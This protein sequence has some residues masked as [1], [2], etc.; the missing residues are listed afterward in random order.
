[1]TM[2]EF[3]DGGMFAMLDQ[4]PGAIQEKAIRPAAQAGA[5]VLYDEVVARVPVSRNGHWF[6]GTTARDAP[7]GQKKQH[8]YWFDAGS[9]RKAIYQKHVPEKSA[10]GIHV[11]HIS[12][13]KT[14]PDAVPYGYMVE[15]GILG[16]A[17]ARP[18]LRP[19]YE[20][21]KQAA[22]DAAEKVLGQKLDEV[23]NGL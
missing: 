23:L 18:F 8:A 22:L 7:K 21:K 6:Y 3:H 14:G 17:P 13:R 15:Y 2:I 11:Y 9:L 20:A 5:Q 10:D 16:R 19:A 12:W 1:M 4:L